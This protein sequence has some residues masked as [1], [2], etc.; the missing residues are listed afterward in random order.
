MLIALAPDSGLAVNVTT[1]VFTPANWSTAQTVT[2]SLPDNGIV[3]TSLS[4][5]IR[6]TV[7]SLDEN[8]DNLAAPAVTVWLTDNDVAPASCF[9]FAEG[10]TG[11]GFQ[12]Y[13]SIGNPNSYGTTASVA[14]MF[15]DG[16]QDRHTY[17]IPACSRTS[18]DVN[19]TV[20]VGRAMYFDYT[21]FGA[22]WQGGHCVIGSP[23]E[24]KEWFFA[25]GYTGADFH[26]WLCLQNP[27]DSSAMVSITYYT[28]E[29]GQLSVRS[30]L[31]PAHTRT[32]IWV[33]QNAGPGYQLS[34]RINVAAGPG[35]IVER[36]MYF[37]YHGWDGG[38][39]VVGY[40]P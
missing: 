20:G 30:V 38:H 14:C 27:G 3:D 33:N 40:N 23:A 7:Q 15:A 36:P 29:A 6:H 10:Y 4:K 13:L 8:Y 2:V 19:A 9:Y 24:A 26:E 18:V 34:C 25:E 21:A 5:Q 1:L 11:S 39:D 37:S 28:Q 12:E 22:N 32:T 35:I 17:E 31:V 16:S